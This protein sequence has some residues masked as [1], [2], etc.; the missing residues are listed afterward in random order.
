MCVTAVRALLT[1]V[2]LLSSLYS[3]SSVFPKSEF[4]IMPNMLLQPG[5]L[6][7]LRSCG[8]P[9]VL[10]VVLVLLVSS[11]QLSPDVVVSNPWNKQI[12]KKKRDKRQ[13]A[14]SNYPDAPTR[15]FSSSREECALC[16]SEHG[17]LLNRCLFF[18]PLFSETGVADADSSPVAEPSN[19]H[20][21]L[22]SD[23]WSASALFL[24]SQFFLPP[25]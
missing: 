12:K 15:Q 5:H 8:L 19:E 22:H 3:V 7:S 9:F 21:S 24:R 18:S 23:G 1:F 4:L 6:S 25:S 10:P 17:A 11:N 14:S 20:I 2:S 13:V 16:A